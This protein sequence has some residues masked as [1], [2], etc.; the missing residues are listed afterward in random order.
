MRFN[1]VA[2]I[3]KRIFACS[4]LH[5][6]NFGFVEKDFVSCVKKM[7]MLSSKRIS[8]QLLL[9]KGASHVLPRGG[10]HYGAETVKP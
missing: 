10:P 5:R 1:C 8:S 3:L 9:P 6:F 7:L 4:S 2:F